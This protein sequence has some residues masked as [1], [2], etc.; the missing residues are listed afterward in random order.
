VVEI[1]GRNDSTAWDHIAIGS[2][3]DG[4]IQPIQLSPTAESIPL[5][6]K[7]MI[8]FVQ[9]FTEIHNMQYLLYGLSPQTVMRKFF[10]TNGRDFIFKNFQD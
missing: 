9:V 3:F 8:T 5:F 6:H 10:Y 7:K 2:D 4:F 1:C